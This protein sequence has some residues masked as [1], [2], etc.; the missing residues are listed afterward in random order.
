MSTSMRSSY[1]RFFASSACFSSSCWS[2]IVKAAARAPSVLSIFTRSRFS[3]NALSAIWRMAPLRASRSSSRSL[4][5]LFALADASSWS[6]RSLRARAWR[7]FSSWASSDSA[8]SAAMSAGVR[9]FDMPLMRSSSPLEMTTL[10]AGRRPRG[11]LFVDVPKSESS[12]PPA[13]RDR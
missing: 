13:F 3:S 2:R 7:C 9:I 5:R 10:F 4:F 11:A 6:M 1:S 12:A 8:R